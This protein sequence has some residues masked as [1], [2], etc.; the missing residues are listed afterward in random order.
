MTQNDRTVLATGAT[1]RQGGSERLP[2]LASNT[3]TAIVPPS[4]K[5]WRG[6]RRKT[7]AYWAASGHGQRPFVS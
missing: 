3:R 2:A 1:G 7:Y 5:R 6:S 4:K